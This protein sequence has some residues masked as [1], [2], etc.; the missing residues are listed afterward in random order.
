MKRYQVIGGCLAIGFILGYI[1]APSADKPKTETKPPVVSKV[2]KKA[3][4]AAAEKARLDAMTPEERDKE[5]KQKAFESTRS[6]YAYMLPQMIKKASFDPDAVKIERPK[7]YS[8]GVCVSANG[9]NRF[10]AYVGYQDYCY[11]Y[12]NEQWSY[13]GPN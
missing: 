2:D 11:I 5:L 3:E 1:A 10:G 13:S 12:K 9:K 4:A 6:L 7:Y 8:N